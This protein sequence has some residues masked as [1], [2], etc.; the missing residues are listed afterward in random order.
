MG[1][2]AITPE[3]VQYELRGTLDM[4]DAGVSEW[5]MTQIEKAERRLFAQCPQTKTLVEREDTATA[6]MAKDIII[7][8][9]AR[10]A[11]TK[12][13][14]VGIKSESEDGYSY[15]V[16]PLTR[17]GNIWF[18]DKDLA[19]LGCGVAG[20]VFMPRSASLARGTIWS[21]GI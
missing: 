8:A 4:N 2:L 3:E 14:E 12:A 11:R 15:T 6:E 7:E 16:D 13:D 20:D 1:I 21:G 9:V 19:L 5:V 10:V 18:P 17:A